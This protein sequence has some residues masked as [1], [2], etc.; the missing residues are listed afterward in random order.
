[1]DDELV[2]SVLYDYEYCDKGG[3]TV[4]IFKDE[5]LYVIKQTNRDWWQVIRSG[6]HRPFYAPTQYLKLL[7]G[8]TSGCDDNGL[9]CDRAS[10]RDVR[11]APISLVDA[12]KHISSDC[13]PLLTASTDDSVLTPGTPDSE[14][15]SDIKHE[16]TI[17]TS[18]SCSLSSGVGHSAS[19][20]VELDGVFVS[21]HNRM[22]SDC[23][24][25]GILSQCNRHQRQQ[26]GKQLN[27]SQRNTDPVPKASLCDLGNREISPLSTTKLKAGEV[28]VSSGVDAGSFLRQYGT[29]SSWRSSGAELAG[30]NSSFKLTARRMAPVPAVQHKGFSRLSARPVQ[31]KDWKHYQLQPS[32]SCSRLQQSQ[33]HQLHRSSSLSRSVDHLFVPPAVRGK[34]PIPHMLDTPLRQLKDGWAEYSDSVC[35]GRLFYYNADTGVS[36][37]KP[38]RRCPS[39][40]APSESEASAVVEVSVPLAPMPVGWR[41]RLDSSGNICYLR[42]SS[43]TLWYHS[44]DAHGRIYYFREGE[45]KSHWS[46]PQCEQVTTGGFPSHSQDIVESVSVS[47]GY[48]A[49][50][51]LSATTSRGITLSSVAVSPVLH[52]LTPDTDVCGNIA[53]RVKNLRLTLEKSLLSEGSVVSSNDC[54]V[55][56]LDSPGWSNFNAI[57]KLT[58]LNQGVLNRTRV[59]NESGRRVRKNWS[60]CHLVLTESHLFLFKNTRGSAHMQG[61]MSG[62]RP[63]YLVDLSSVAISWQPEKSSRR[64]VFQLAALNGFQLLLQDDSSTTAQSW[65][66][67][68]VLMASRVKDASICQ[69]PLRTESATSICGSIDDRKFSRTFSI[70]GG[71]L[72]SNVARG[73]TTATYETPNSSSIRDLLKK[74]FKSRPAADALR[75]RG[76]LRDEPVFGCTL[77]ALCQGEGCMIPRF[78]RECV[79]AIESRPNFMQVVGLYRMSANLSLVQKLRCQVDQ[80]RYESIRDETEVHV[81]TGALKLFLRE[82]REPLIPFDQLRTTLQLAECSADSEQCNRQLKLL[83][84]QLPACNAHTLLLLL[85]HLNRVIDLYEYNRM[86]AH[87]VST[88]FGPTVMWPE[89][90]LDCLALGMMQQNRAV[91]NMLNCLRLIPTDLHQDLLRPA[92]TE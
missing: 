39:P 63:E 49:D 30:H 8:Q 3:H 37:W 65:F 91:D 79:A 13:L 7:E 15:P 31:P 5:E 78:V 70:R 25:H 29:F 66:D 19:G 87:N 89:R 76:I 47:S 59:S 85:Q 44:Q 14:T 55:N 54:E 36:R 67:A 90:Q 57:G 34:P 38:P 60:P 35:S 27:N 22:L 82:L 81:L 80:D 2:V 61:G 46:L 11:R 23:S 62:C 6:D 64:N 68:I 4:Q 50:F 45:F 9:R 53:S 26:T 1:M 42:S 33:G 41:R 51:P 20:E 21:N 92:S 58:I 40:H 84:R 75:H 17:S 10:I 72:V 43:P 32:G 77:S 83:F 28:A 56:E 18:S 74:F 86:D 12:E 88:V 24:D 73:P 71:R 48:R 52:T 16:Q 69:L